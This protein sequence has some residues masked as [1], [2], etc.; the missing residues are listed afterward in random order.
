M[1]QPANAYQVLLQPGNSE[2]GQHLIW[3]TLEDD[4]MVDHLEEP[5]RSTEQTSLVRFLSLLPLDSKL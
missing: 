3:R 1:V 5:A 2:N 4:R